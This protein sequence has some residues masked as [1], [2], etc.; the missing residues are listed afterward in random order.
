MRFG[1]DRRVRRRADFVRIQKTGRAVRTRHFVLLVAVREER[2][3]S[4]LGIVAA[5]TVGNA[6][7]RNRVKRLC[8]E[9]FRLA[10]ELLPAG[11]DLVVIAK[12]GAADLGL[13]DVQ[14]EWSG[15]APRLAAEC[16]KVLQPRPE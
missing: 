16:K 15:V 4:R 11:V 9:S 2:G 7:A 13:R 12:P 3:P 10:P 5:R 6:V 1:R 8:R 14:A